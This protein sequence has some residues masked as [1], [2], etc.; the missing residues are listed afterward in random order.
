MNARATVWFQSTSIKYE[1]IL[2]IANV[3]SRIEVK[4]EIVANSIP[5][6]ERTTQSL[7]TWHAQKIDKL[8]SGHMLLCHAIYM[9]HFSIQIQISSNALIKKISVDEK[10]L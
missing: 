1:K 2:R 8:S 3:L 6:Q 9:Q 7:T 5:F 10:F 4:L